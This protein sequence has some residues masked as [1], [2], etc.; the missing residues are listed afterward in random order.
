MLFQPDADAARL[1]V[2][3]VGG[4]PSERDAGLHGTLQHA[5]ARV[6]LRGELDVSAD[7]GRPAA[8]GVRRPRPRE[9]QLTAD[10]RPAPAGSI[11][12]KDTHLGVLDP[13]GRSRILPGHTGRPDAL[14]EEPRLIENEDWL[15][16]RSPFRRAAYRRDWPWWCPGWSW[17]WTGWRVRHLRASRGFLAL[18]GRGPQPRSMLIGRL[19]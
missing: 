11:R 6:G 4:E 5:Q 9:I 13:P 17:W 7:A 8:P 12:Q 14:F 16:V 1:P 18:G 10:Q 3:F 2:H 15:Q 19:P